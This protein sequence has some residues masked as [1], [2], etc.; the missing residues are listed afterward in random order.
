[1]SLRIGK[2]V[3]AL[4]R[5]PGLTAGLAVAAALALSAG[6]AAQP[7]C[8]QSLTLAARLADPAQLTL[9]LDAP[10]RPYAALTLAYGPL[11]IVEQSSALG[12]LTLDLPRL[13]GAQS[14]TVD[15]GDKTL[16]AAVPPGSDPAR[17]FA[18]VTWSDGP[19]RG[20]LE[21]QIPTRP[22]SPW[23]SIRRT[24]PP[25][26]RLWSLMGPCFCVCLSR[27]TPA[28]PCWPQRSPPTRRRR[29]CRLHWHCRSATR[30]CRPSRSRSDRPIRCYSWFPNVSKTCR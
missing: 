9:T 16:S 7:Q 20:I 25:V 24:A 8:P 14:V 17:G 3:Q 4:P 5:P 18:A 28:E 27:R 11:R 29:R 21:A 2:E 1:M 19:A 13:V 10:C 23:G 6:A 15:L 12:T 30:P 26:Q 22:G